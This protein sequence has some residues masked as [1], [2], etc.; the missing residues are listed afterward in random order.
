MPFDP[1]LSLPIHETFQQTI[2]GEGYWYGSPCDFIRF[3]G[4]PVG[5]YFCDTGYG[6]DGSLSP[7]APKLNR[8]TLSE[9]L[10]ELKSRIVVITGGEPVI[11][12]ELPILVEAI[13]ST[14][15]LPGIP[16]KADRDL[17]VL[18][19][20]G[21]YLYKPSPHPVPP[22]LPWVVL[23]PKEHLE[24]KFPVLDR[25]WEMANEVKIVVSKGNEIEFYKDKLLQYYY[26]C[27]GWDR[28]TCI[29]GEGAS[30][31]D[32]QCS[33]SNVN[34]NGT[35]TPTPTPNLKSIALE[36]LKPRV[37]IYL[38][39]EWNDRENTILMVLELLKQ[40]PYFKMSLQAHKFIG[41]Y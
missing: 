18:E 24:P 25:M 29:E 1:D 40:Y 15:A 7:H 34:I 2:Q 13:L 41:V 8:R 16:K 22:V 20:S 28:E 26:P 36:T 10:G 37:P 27:L 32:E 14:D 9:V 3:Y 21:S 6:N 33:K 4:C 17:V 11:H 19:T 30:N 23:S 5:C 12:K 35:P 39:P 38:Q 31:G